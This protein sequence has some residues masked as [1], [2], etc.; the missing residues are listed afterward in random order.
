MRC[1]CVVAGTQVIETEVPSHEDI[2]KNG[3][4]SRIF[5]VDCEDLDA[6]AVWEFD[7]P[8]HLPYGLH[9]G[10]LNWEHMK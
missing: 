4:V 2:E 10:F 7:L 3:L 5:V 8:Y 1:R 6:G 9:S